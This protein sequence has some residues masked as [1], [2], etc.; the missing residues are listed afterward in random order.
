MANTNTNTKEISASPVAPIVAC[1]LLGQEF[2]RRKDAITNA[3]F[4]HAEQIEELADGFAF[5]F[6]GFDPSAGRIMEFI[7][8]ERECCPFFRFELIVE[9]DDGP[10]WLRLRGSDEVK[11]FVL[12]ELG[13][14]AAVAEGR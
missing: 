4:R 13:I 14:D 10:V 11:T 2:M 5:R 9:P 3:L 1:K 8:A 12:G 7:T 6:A